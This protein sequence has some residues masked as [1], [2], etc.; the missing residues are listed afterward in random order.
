HE[1]ERAGACDVA[2]NFAEQRR[3]LRAGNNNILAARRQFAETL[4]FGSAELAAFHH[5][6]VAADLAHG[7]AVERHGVVAGTDQDITRHWSRTSGGSN[8]RHSNAKVRARIDTDGA[9]PAHC[10]GIDPAAALF[11]GASARGGR[12]F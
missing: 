1:A 4:E 12:R 2:G 5:D 6:R 10:A 9:A 7:L 3:L 8:Y 11:G